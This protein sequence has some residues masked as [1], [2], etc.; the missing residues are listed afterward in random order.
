VLEDEDGAGIPANMT[1]RARGWVSEV[2]TVELKSEGSGTGPAPLRRYVVKAHGL[3]E[4][5]NAEWPHF[6]AL[7]DPDGQGYIETSFAVKDVFR[8]SAFDVDDADLFY[9]HPDPYAS[10]AISRLP[11]TP[12]DLGNLPSLVSDGAWNP[13]WTEPRIKYVERIATEWRGWNTLYESGTQILFHPDLVVETSA[14]VPYY[15]S[16]VLWR[17]KAEAAGEADEGQC[18]EANPE[19]FTIRPPFNAVRIVGKDP[20]KQ[21]PNVAVHVIDRDQPSIDDL[22][23]PNGYLGEA[24]FES[25]VSKLAVGTYACKQVA[26][27]LLKRKGRRIRGW[28]VVVMKAPWTFEPNPVEV[29]RCV[30]L[31]ERG[32]YLITRLTWRL[33]GKRQDIPD[34]YVWRSALTL[35]QLPS[36]ATTAL[37]AGAYPGVGAV[38]E[39]A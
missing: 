29:G 7:V 39:E 35:E 5:L 11:G 25:V 22:N 37:E 20:K 1:L 10:T 34:T 31:K 3:L 14:G 2:D 8:K 15:I 27:L 17:S 19:P 21:D 6:P 16:A 4:R 30:T 12:A 36:T 18:F 28:N 13:D 23:A 33:L 26:R 9:W 32:N 38:A 24:R